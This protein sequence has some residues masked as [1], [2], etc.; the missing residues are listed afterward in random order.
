[1][2]STSALRLLFIIVATAFFAACA[3]IGHPEGGP[4]DETP[5]V[6][7]RSNPK[8]GQ[9]RFDGS[10]ITVDFDENVSIDDPMNKVVVSPAQRTTP[11]VTANG[12]RVTVE[13]RDSL[14]PNT[15]YTIDFADAIK[16]LNESNVLDGFALDFATGDTIDTLRVSGICNPDSTISELLQFKLYLQSGN[17]IEIGVL[18]YTDMSGQVNQRSM[19]YK[20][21]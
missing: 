14:V 4:R 11:V 12:R 6:Y 13:L 20:Q 17:A 16:D 7:V 18:Q 21:P 15:T 10:K 3:S 8:P 5:P 1:M 19:M 2:R 9:L